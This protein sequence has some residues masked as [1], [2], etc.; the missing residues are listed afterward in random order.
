M[1]QVSTL[2]SVTI[3]TLIE[4]KWKVM[5]EMARNFGILL[6]KSVMGVWGRSTVP[7]LHPAQSDPNVEANVSMSNFRYFDE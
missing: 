6:L 1:K 2:T 3:Y 4:L 5:I 7:F